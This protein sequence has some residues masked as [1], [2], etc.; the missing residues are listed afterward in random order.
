MAI[1]TNEDDAVASGTGDAKKDAQPDRRSAVNLGSLMSRYGSSGAWTAD[2]TEYVQKIRD[3]LEDP[4]YP[5][6]ITVKRISN[7][8]IAFTS[9]GF[10][11]VLLL[12]IDIINNMHEMLGDVK[13]FKAAKDYKEMF[14]EG[15]LLNIV[16]VNRYMFSRY[17]QMA[18]YIS[19]SLE[20]RSDKA[21]NDLTINSFTNQYRLVIDTDLGNVK[22]FF[23]AYSPSGITCADFGFVASLIDNNEVQN[24][25][26]QPIP[27]FG[28]TGYV[29]FVRDDQTGMFTPIVHATE[30]ISALP[31]SKIMALAMPL[32]AEMFIKHGLWKQPFTAMGKTD[33][34]IGHLVIGDD[35][36][37]CEV[38]NDKD[39]RDLFREYI[40]HPYL[41]I[42]VMAGQASVPGIER[43]IS[44]DQH[45]S[46][47]ADMAE[48]LGV[49]VSTF[50][51]GIA[52]NVFREIIGITET[53]KDISTTGIMDTRDINYLFAVS[54]LGYS[55]K[56]EQLQYRIDD[57]IRRF[58]MLKDMINTEILPTHNA[59]TCLI[60]GEFI[61]QMS[62][63][64]ANKID[65][66]FPS[67]TDMPTI[68]IGGFADRAYQPSVNLFTPN[69]STTNWSAGGY[70]N[71]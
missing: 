10:S 46:L 53:G 19:N 1:I 8:S 28:V 32:I 45:S 35:Q 38:K 52:E 57:P 47:K 5:I 14:S 17:S 71:G 18:N 68:N 69:S 50:Q 59:V 66:Q 64:V 12:D 24:K 42:D 20:A 31:S 70:L 4:S 54:K 29:E 7:N 39:F 65:I 48:F 40:E 13:L 56:V 23:E 22:Q 9:G 33:L 61:R 11:I 27:M 62:S 55:A 6:K 43:L 3:I 36:K 51:C 30:I 37:P 26:H 41:C 21:I 58:E 34:N 44:T 63:I 2:A 25:F 16:T 67:S 49:D 60:D 15:R